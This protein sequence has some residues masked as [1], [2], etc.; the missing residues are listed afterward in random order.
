MAAT[1]EPRQVPHH[2]HPSGTPLEA[3]PHAQQVEAPGGWATFAMWGTL[4]LVYGLIGYKVTIDQHV[5]VFDALDRL[6]RAFL[7]WHNDPPKLAAVGFLFP[8]LTTMAFLPF[9]AIKPIAT[10]LVALPV[11]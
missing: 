10:S 2:G 1:V 8:P 5:V 4:A 11:M 9:A 7:V 6:T 3:Q